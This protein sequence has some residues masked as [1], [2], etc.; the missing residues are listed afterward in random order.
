MRSWSWAAASRAFAVIWLG[1]ENRLLRLLLE[2]SR[3]A[4]R[5]SSM[6]I[7]A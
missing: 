6:K 5:A 4:V 1:R 7:A 3:S 2:H